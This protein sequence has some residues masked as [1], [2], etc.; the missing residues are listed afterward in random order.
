MGE[1]MNFDFEQ[2]VRMDYAHLCLTI[3]YDSACSFSRGW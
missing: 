3:F 1:I 2:H